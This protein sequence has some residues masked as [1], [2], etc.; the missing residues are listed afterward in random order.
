MNIGH[1]ISEIKAED[2]S[3]QKVEAKYFLNTILLVFSLAMKQT[4]EPKKQPHLPG[5]KCGHRLSFEGR[6]FGTVEY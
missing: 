4:N 3:V 6:I 5:Q 2:Y 1:I